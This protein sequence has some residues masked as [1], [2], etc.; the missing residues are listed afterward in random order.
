[1]KLYLLPFVLLH[2]E[3]LSASPPQR[4]RSANRDTPKASARKVTASTSGVPLGVG[5]DQESRQRLLDVGF[6]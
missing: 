2:L 5:P 3:A 1:M 4:I 6:G